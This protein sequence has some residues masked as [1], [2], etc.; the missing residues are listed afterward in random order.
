[1]LQTPA[2]QERLSKRNKKSTEVEKKEPEFTS[3]TDFF[4]HQKQSEGKELPVVWPNTDLSATT[5]KLVKK[6]KD[7][8]RKKKVKQETV[9]KSQA[10]ED[11]DTAVPDEEHA[12][13]QSCQQASSELE[14]CARNKLVL[15]NHVFETGL[16]SQ[17]QSMVSRVLS[18]PKQ[19]GRPSGS[20]NSPS[21][22]SA[23][24][25]QPASQKFASL[26]SIPLDPRL[27]PTHS[28]SLNHLSCLDSVINF[29]TSVRRRT[30]FSAVARC[31]LETHKTC[32]TKEH[33]K[34]ILG[35]WRDA[36]KVEWTRDSTAEPW[37]L[38]LII[39]NNENESLNVASRKNY[40]H[41]LLLV[42]STPLPV[43][44]LPP[45]PEQAANSNS[46]LSA[47]L[48]TTN[49]CSNSFSASLLERVREKEELLK[50]KSEERAARS[51]YSLQQLLEVSRMIKLFYS[52]RKVNNQ[53]L[54]SIVDKV[55]NARR[56]ENLS[57]K[58]EVL[59]LIEHLCSIG[60]G[61]LTVVKSDDL[62]VLRIDPRVQLEDLKPLFA[63]SGA[64]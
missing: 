29:F 48:S 32:V 36:Y 7:K 61:W 2:A 21:Y 34:N 19:R 9:L 8:R 60:N 6:I 28:Q 46:F 55:H 43:A 4:R 63:A 57:S 31:V 58:Q 45:N 24:S 53:F 16:S 39:D 12:Q 13:L 33:L 10:N 26:L 54:A 5:S 11:L 49:T 38:L 50:K 3:F 40:Y 51:D 23:V 27:P 47:F 30:L 64:C 56:G 35:V 14:D 20:F 59:K 44:S 25:N 42:A 41:S 18:P 37:E 15:T 62:D 52:N 22:V 1:M 17:T